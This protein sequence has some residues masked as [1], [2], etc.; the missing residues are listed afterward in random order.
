MSADAGDFENPFEVA[1]PAGAEGWERLYPYYS[2]FSE[3]RREV[4]E[5]QFWFWDSMHYPEVMYPFDMVMPEQTSV[6]LNQNTTLGTW[7]CRPRGASTTGIVNGYVY[8]SPNRSRT[9]RRSRAGPSTSE[10]APATTS[11]TGPRCTSSGSRRPRRAV[12]A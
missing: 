1:P 8:I 11:P 6:I 12:S 2:L 4:E 7:S 3:D 5:E 10:P 9:R